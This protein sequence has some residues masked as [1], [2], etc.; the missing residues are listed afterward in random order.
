M[1]R[2]YLT[3]IINDHKTQ[4]KQQ[5]KLTT[6]ITFF[7]SKDCEEIRIMYSASDNIDV[8]IGIETDKITE[9]L[10]DSFLQR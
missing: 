3:H 6:A 1:I 2:P 4:G 7:S 8:M 5:I 10:F 9:D